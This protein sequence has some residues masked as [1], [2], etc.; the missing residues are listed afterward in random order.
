[1]QQPVIEQQ[2]I[3]TL[4]LRADDS[5]SLSIFVDLEVRDDPVK[6]AIRRRHNVVIEAFE[7]QI[8]AGRIFAAIT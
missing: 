5:I 7:Y 8:H 2:H 3:T 6:D 4:K 1:M